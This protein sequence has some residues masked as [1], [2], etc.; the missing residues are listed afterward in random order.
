MDMNTNTT[1]NVDEVKR[2]AVVTANWIAIV[3]LGVAGV[4]IFIWMLDINNTA[5][6]I[7]LNS[8]WSI[9][10]FAWAVVAT[11]CY[12]V[13]TLVIFERY[14]TE[15]TPG[16]AIV[17]KPMLYDFLKRITHGKLWYTTAMALVAISILAVGSVATIATNTTLGTKH[18]HIRVMDDGRVL[19]PGTVVPHDPFK[20]TSVA[21]PVSSFRMQFVTLADEMSVGSG[22]KYTR[23]VELDLNID[24][25]GNASFERLLKEAGAAKLGMGKDK[26]YKQTWAQRAYYGY[27][28]RNLLPISELSK[29]LVAELDTGTLDTGELDM[30]LWVGK[31]LK[32]A[33]LPLWVQSIDVRGVSISKIE[34]K[35]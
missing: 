34:V 8:E 9:D 21:V 6:R 25:V 13:G 24:I 7:M 12:L 5:Q 11:A 3:A 4:L 26:L 29:Q 31:K 33:S 10:I 20:V 27:S 15:G 23:I 35:H 28:L 2:G 30:R 19:L 1:I 22:N 17:T 32:E 16:D 18:G 14:S